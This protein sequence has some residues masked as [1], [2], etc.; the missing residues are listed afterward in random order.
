MSFAH[1]L[2]LFGDT[3]CVLKGRAVHGKIIT[4][5]F[6]LDAYTYNHLM[7]LYLK[8]NRI[9]DA[10]KVFDTMADRNLVS[11]TAL[12][13]WHSRMGMPEEAL[14]CFRLM[15]KD[16]CDPN[17]YTY[18]GA[19]SACASLGD[20]RAG[21]EI[22]GRIYRH[23]QE[24]NGKVSNCLVNMYGKCGLLKSAR[25]VFDATLKPDLVSWTSIL[26]SYCQCGENVEGLKIFMRSQEDGVEVNEFSCASV[27]G[28][29]A[30]LENLKVGMQVHPL[31][32]KCGLGFD[33]FVVTAL[34]N[35]YAKCGE[36]D[37]AHQAFMEVDKPQ[38]QAWTALMGGCAQQGKAIEAFDLFH[39]FH[40]L[41]LKPSERTFSSVLGALADTVD[42]EVGTQLHSLIIK[43]GFNSFIF[44]GNAILDFYSKCGHHGEAIELLKD[45][46][47]EG[48]EPNLH[49]YPSI[50][51]ICG[52]IPAIEWGKQ[53][54]CHILKP[55]FDSNVVVGSALI[56]MYAKC[57]RLSEARKVFDILVTK[58][59]VS[60]NTILVGYAQHG[61]GR[62]ALEIYNIMR[63]NGIK[64]NGI[65]F[66][67]VLSACGHVGLVE[68]GWHHFN[69]MIKDHGIPPRTDH[70]ASLVSLFARKG[71]TK[72]AFELIRSFPMESNKVV[73]RCLLSGCKIHKDVALGRYAAEKILSIDPEDTSAHIML[74][75]IFA[76][77][78]MWDEAAQVRKIMKE[79]VLKK[80][81]G[82]SWAELK[83]SIYYFSAT[84]YTQ[85]QE[86][87]LHEV[88]DGLTAQLFDT[89]Y[90]PD[91]MFVLH[92]GE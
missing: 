57:G 76:E 85:L 67:G 29:C 9:N 91:A 86:T 89:G 45:M 2:R 23:E 12:I 59:L 75:N 43:M 90:M 10:C 16:G 88:L 28:A 15:A 4:S 6:F 35:L 72:R 60:W 32:I 84:H 58:N 68:E 34:I 65:T 37:Y 44:V 70:L 78:K 63:S 33:N 49:T 26:S 53:T 47:I 42:V 46:L 27:L 79:K 30:S 73:W 80:D 38:L 92:C 13:S 8:I 3:Q 74:S 71:Q 64:P 69:S 51:S 62:E 54:H 18:V 36:L 24:L 40:S 5:G 55:G 1:L 14:N 11:W 41:G 87:N 83:N 48:F 39:K 81:T 20:A 21:K 52:D 7:S 66:L 22:H 17:N 31:V 25:L 82:Y 77:A 61:F 50:F 56:D 19:I